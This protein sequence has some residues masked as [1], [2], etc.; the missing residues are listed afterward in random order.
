MDKTEYLEKLKNCNVWFDYSRSQK[1]VAEKI[2]HNC[3]LDKDFLTKLKIENNYDEYVALWSNAHYHYG[4]AIENGLKG[5]IVKHQPNSIDVEIKGKNVILKNIG[6]KAGKTHNLVKLAETAGIFDA[7]VGLYK[8]NDSYKGL[9]SVLLHLSDMIKWGARYPIPN[10]LEARNKF[11][12]EV[13][14]I[15]VYGFHILDVMEPLFEYFEQERN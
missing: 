8:C 3:I 12:N 4:I 10:N 11:D 15:I 14:P 9:R 6:G 13:P 5:I 7:K 2:L 1:N